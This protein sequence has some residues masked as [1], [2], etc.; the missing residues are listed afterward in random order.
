VLSRPKRE[1]RE[2]S[3]DEMNDREFGAILVIGTTI[4]ILVTA[5]AAFITNI[6]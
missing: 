3:M 5:F 6:Y 2:G 1:E 4:I